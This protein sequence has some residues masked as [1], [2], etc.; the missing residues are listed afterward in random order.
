MIYDNFSNA[1]TENDLVF[2][3]FYFFGR[4]KGL[5]IMVK[6][7]NKT[8]DYHRTKA[9]QA[10]IEVRREDKLDRFMLFCI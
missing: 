2:I 5:E 10:K 9:L 8:N 3:F 6:L 1:L 4:L 7:E